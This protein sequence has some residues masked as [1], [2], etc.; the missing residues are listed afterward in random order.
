[1]ACTTVGLNRNFYY[2]SVQLQTPFGV[3][4]AGHLAANHLSDMGGVAGES[5]SLSMFENEVYG[6]YV[7]FAEPFFAIYARTF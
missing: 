4:F 2:F 5:F 3:H 1:M 6:F 7:F